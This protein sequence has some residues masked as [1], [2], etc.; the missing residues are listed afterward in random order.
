VIAPKLA[1][2]CRQQIV[3][4]NRAGAGGAIGAELAAA[5]VPDGY[6]IWLGQTNNLAIGPA[7]RPKKRV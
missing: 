1:R 7:L 5:A 2:R 6:T 4:D 3:V